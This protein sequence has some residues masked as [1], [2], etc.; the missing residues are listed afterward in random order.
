MPSSALAAPSLTISP[1][2][3]NPD[4]PYGWSA[5][6]T[7]A[8]P[9]SLLQVTLDGSGPIALR[10]DANGELT[11]GFGGS[12][13]PIDQVTIDGFVD[14]DEDGIKDLNEPSFAASLNAPCQTR[15]LP[16]GT[17]RGSA[18]T[19]LSFPT[20]VHVSFDARSGPLGENPSGSVVLTTDQGV[21]A[22]TVT[23]V[24]V[25]GTLASVGV[26]LQ[27]TLPGGA[28]AVVIHVAPAH[29]TMDI[30]TVNAA[31]M[32]CPFPHGGGFQ[33][34]GDIVIAAAAPLPTSKDQC[35]RGGWKAYGFKNQ[36]QCVSFVATGAKNPPR[37]D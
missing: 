7:G 30:V 28:S 26:A 5:T 13:G 11:S 24:G 25:K 14:L 8:P 15:P 2:C 27:G 31:P 35:K 34:T 18:D 23:C 4:F 29:G 16:G 10:A 21:V 3:E 33:Y 37:G 20:T 19:F 32:E 1:A 17:V 12:S 6:L 9:N 22:G 36:G